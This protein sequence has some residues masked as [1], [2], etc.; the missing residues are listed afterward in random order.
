MVASFWL[1]CPI[2]P[3]H[4][5]G[6]GGGGYFVRHLYLSTFPPTLGVNV[7]YEMRRNRLFVPVGAR[8]RFCTQTHGCTMSHQLP[9]QAPTPPPPH[10]QAANVTHKP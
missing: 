8:T 9:S 10:T 1:L 6:G 5:S 4:N 7:H 2:G 3:G